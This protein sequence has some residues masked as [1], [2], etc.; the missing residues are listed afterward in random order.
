MTGAAQLP[1]PEIGGDSINRSGTPAARRRQAVESFGRCAECLGSVGAGSSIFAVT[2]GQWSM[3]DAIVHVMSCCA[4]PVE[5]SLWTWTVAEYEV[6]CL[7]KLREDRRILSGRLIIDA[8]ARTK[9]GIVEQTKMEGVLRDWRRRFGPE[10]IRYVF[11][12]AK[13]ARVSVPGG[14][15]FLLRGSMNLNFNPRFEQF[16]LTEGGP[17]FDLV[18]RIESELPILPDTCGKA[19]A[20]A[21]SRLGDAFTAEQL[22][23][24]FGGLKVWA[25]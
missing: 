3:I 7:G 9:S 21:A 5:V 22:G 23:R 25:K 6:E 13:L 2:R 16:D 1:L 14:L 18:A 17:E 4:E 19:E 12:H 20:R 10:S 8:G 24:F 15:R 11:N